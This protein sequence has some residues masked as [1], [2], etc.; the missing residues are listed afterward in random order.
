MRRRALIAASI[1]VPGLAAASTARAGD[2]PRPATSLSMAGVG[3]PIIVD[4][5][6]R[7]YVFVSLRLHLGGSTTPESLRPKEAY[8]RDALVR[9]AH[10]T[11]FVVA[12]DWTRVDVAALSASLMRSAASIAGRGAVARVEVVSQSPRLR[13]GLR[14][15]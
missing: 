15:G 7:N 14:A 4:G 10:R 1:A 3:V 9:A 5:R 11:P 2:P 8:L 13:T 6:V 12:D